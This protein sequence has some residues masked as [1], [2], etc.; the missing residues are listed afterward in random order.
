MLTGDG[1]N[2]WVDKP[3][4]FVVSASGRI[5]GTSE[6]SICDGAELD[7]LMENFM[8]VDLHFLPYKHGTASKKDSLELLPKVRLAKR[9]DFE[10]NDRVYCEKSIRF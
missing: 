9:L 10:L 2:R 4:N 1:K 5:G 7:H 6:H 8:F 3:L